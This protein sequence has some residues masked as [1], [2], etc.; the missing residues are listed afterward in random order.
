MITIASLSGSVLLR[1]HED[2]EDDARYPAVSDLI[3]HISSG[4]FGIRPAP[5]Q[6]S[7]VREHDTRQLEPHELVPGGTTVTYIVTPF[8]PHDVPEADRFISASSRGLLT[9]VAQMLDRLMLDRLVDPNITINGCTGLHMALD[10]QARLGDIQLRELVTLFMDSH[11][12]PNL[13]DCHGS[14][15]LSLAIRTRILE[16]TRFDIVDELCRGLADVNVRDGSTY[17]PL[18]MAAYYG[19]TSIARRLL[20]FGA[21]LNA[22]AL[23]LPSSWWVSRDEHQDPW[24][25]GHETAL[26][27]ASGRGH[28]HTAHLLITFKAQLEL[29]DGRGQSWLQVATGSVATLYQ[30]F[31]A[32]TSQQAT[33]G[34][35]HTN[36]WT[37]TTEAPAQTAASEVLT[38]AP[39]AFAPPVRLILPIA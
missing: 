37:A 2:T 15:P 36:A 21:D 19:R 11:S 14:S 34:R 16:S 20:E 9:I 18:H 5:Q 28:L 6:I 29:L 17:T 7:I 26:H 30:A 4:T 33:S 24:W 3:G 22:E 35:V 23:P 32:T 25:A 12:D 8:N 10:R 13:L 31:L 27:F 39:P 38:T 1:V